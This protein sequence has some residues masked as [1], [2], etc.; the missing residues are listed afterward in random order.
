MNNNKFILDACCSGRMFWFNKEQENT[1][2]IDNRRTK[3]GDNKYRPN[4]IVNPDELMDFR[5]MKFKDKSFKLVVFDP[6]HIKSKNINAINS[7][8]LYGCLN[9]DTWKDDLIKGF[10][11]CWRVLEDYGILVFKWNESSIKISKILKLFNKE[12]LFGNRQGTK[13]NTHWLV[14]MKLPEEVDVKEE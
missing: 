14:F 3:Y 5:K 13:L 1:L 10:D 12:P 7:T 11:E 6:P 9:Y 8:M 2:Y 4:H